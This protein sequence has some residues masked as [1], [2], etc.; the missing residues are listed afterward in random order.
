[1]DN[2][3]QYISNYISGPNNCRNIKFM[4]VSNCP[5]CQIVLLAWSVSNC[6]MCQIV[7]SPCIHS[8][9]WIVKNFWSIWIERKL[10]FCVLGGMNLAQVDLT[11]SCIDLAGGSPRHRLINNQTFQINF[12]IGS[13]EILAV[14]WSDVAF[15]ELNF[16][17]ISVCFS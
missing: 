3:N 11:W 6:P 9:G 8:N 13:S 5:R 15:T 10:Y 4:M 1:M 16:N 7:P 12:R 14:F 17:T 2:G